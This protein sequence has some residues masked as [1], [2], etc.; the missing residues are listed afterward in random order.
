MCIR[1]SDDREHLAC[2]IST[3]TC[4][5]RR[6]MAGWDIDQFSGLQLV[7]LTEQRKDQ[8]RHAEAAV[9]ELI[10][11]DNVEITSTRRLNAQAKQI[12]FVKLRVGLNAPGHFLQ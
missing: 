7:I 3:G 4:F 9:S 10:A 5:E 1:D 6:G 11:I 12:A 2:L 8:I